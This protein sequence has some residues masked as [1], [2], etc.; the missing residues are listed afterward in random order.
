MAH[1][2]A[3]AENEW[4]TAE[5]WESADQRDTCAGRDQ[6][7]RTQVSRLRSNPQHRANAGRESAARR[8]RHPWLRTP[9]DL[10]ARLFLNYKSKV[11]GGDI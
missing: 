4:R 7:L 8:G 5:P 10:E 6:N 9:D 2:Q 3:Y 11:R 1:S